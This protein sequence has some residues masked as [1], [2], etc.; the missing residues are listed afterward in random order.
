MAAKVPVDKRTAVVVGKTGA[1]KS[2]VANHILGANVFVVKN[3]LG[4]VTAVPQIQERSHETPDGRTYNVRVID[5]P[6]FFDTDKSIKTS[7]VLEQIKTFVSRTVRD[8]VN[9][10]Y[11]VFKANRFTSEERKTFDT[12]IGNF[13]DD[14][15]AVSALIITNCESWSDDERLDYIAKFRKNP[16]TSDI[17]AFMQKGIFCVGFPDPKTTKAKIM[18]AFEED[19]QKDQDVIRQQLYYSTETCNLFNMTFLQKCHRVCT[20]L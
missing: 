14:I 10:V 4:S 2:N 18:K 7:N 9:L 1:G 8:G 20:I 17:A 15:S 16:D 6:G 3:S 11:F 5:T 12:I 19:I 13:K